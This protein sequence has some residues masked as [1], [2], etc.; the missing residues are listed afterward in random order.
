MLKVSYL[1]SKY[2]HK[3]F[4][5]LIFFFS[6]CFFL[7]PSSIIQ[8]YN[9]NLQLPFAEKQSI[10]QTS[11]NKTTFS[12][13]I[14]NVDGDLTLYGFWKI[15]LG[16]GAGFT[17]FP[18]LEWILTKNGI[19]DGLIFD[20]SRLFSLN[21]KTDTGIFFHFF[22]NDNVDD[23]EFTFRYD[24]GKFFNSFYITNKFQE[25]E[26]NPYRSLKGGKPQDINFGFDMGNRIYKRKI[27]YTI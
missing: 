17:L 26:V 10:D 2:M 6:I 23:T 12:F 4:F 19:T 14:G 21:W 7:F 27:R 20:Q 11:D 9:K 18:E 3:F 8:D 24:V 25:Y 22:I 5:I 15:K 1:L 16:Y 13:R